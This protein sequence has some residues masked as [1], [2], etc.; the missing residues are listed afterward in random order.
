MALLRNLRFH[1]TGWQWLIFPSRSLSPDPL[2]AGSSY[3]SSKQRH[4]RQTQVQPIQTP[5]SPVGKEQGDRNKPP[6]NDTS[7]K[8]K[9]TEALYS[10]TPNDGSCKRQRIDHASSFSINKDITSVKS[11]RARR[12]LASSIS[13]PP[14]SHAASKRI[15]HVQTFQPDVFDD[16]GSIVG[17]S[18]NISSTAPR[19]TASDKSIRATPQGP[20]AMSVASTDSRSE[21]RKR[22]L[23]QLAD[24]T[25]GRLSTRDQIRRGLTDERMANVRNMLDLEPRPAE[26]K[27]EHERFPRKSADSVEFELNQNLRQN[28]LRQ[29]TRPE[30]PIS[31]AGGSANV[32]DQSADREQG[33]IVDRILDARIAPSESMI[34]TRIGHTKEASKNLDPAAAKRKH[35]SPT[36]HLKQGEIRNFSAGPYRTAGSLQVDGTARRGAMANTSLSS[37]ITAFGFGPSAPRL[38]RKSLK[39][40]SPRPESAL[41]S[42]EHVDNTNTVQVSGNSS[43]EMAA[44]QLV[45]EQAEHTRQLSGDSAVTPRL[46]EVRAAPIVRERIFETATAAKV[47]LSDNGSRLDLGDTTLEMSPFPRRRP[48]FDDHGLAGS[49]DPCSENSNVKASPEVNRQSP[50][51]RLQERKSPGTAQNASGSQEPRENE[52]PSSNQ[53]PVCYN[54][55]DDQQNEMN[56]IHEREKLVS[57]KRTNKHFDETHANCFDQ[58]PLRLGRRMA[59]TP[60]LALADVRTY[61]A[62]RE[63]TMIESCVNRDAISNPKTFLSMPEVREAL[64]KHLKD[65][66]DDHQYKVQ[67]ELAKALDYQNAHIQSLWTHLPSANFNGMMGV[68]HSSS[69]FQ[70]MQPIDSST[71]G[72]AV[73]KRHSRFY[74][75]NYRHGR[76]TAK[77][78]TACPISS[79]NPHAP[80]V[81]GFTGDMPKF[82]HYVSIDRNILGYNTRQMRVWPYF[83]MEDLGG[84]EETEGQAQLKLHFDLDV[85]DWPRKVHRIQQVQTY[86]PYVEAF[87][88]EIGCSMGDILY[89]LLEP[90]EAVIEAASKGCKSRQEICTED[91]NR[92]SSSTRW[93]R[94]F[95][96]LTKPSKTALRKAAIAC[97]IFSD[98]VARYS[99]YSKDLTM[100]HIA[101]KSTAACLVEADTGMEA[102]AA[103]CEI[104][105]IYDCPYHGAMR[106]HENSSDADDD[107][108]IASEDA[109]DA[110]YPPN[111]NYKV[112]VTLP[113]RSVETH[114]H[115]DP[116]QGHKQSKGRKGVDWWMEKSVSWDHSERGPFYPCYHPGLACDQAQCRCFRDK[117]HCEKACGCSA[118]C[119][120]QFH[121]CT[122]K[123]GNKKR[124]LQ[125]D[126]CECFKMNRE[127]DPD[128]CGTCGVQSVLNPESEDTDRD[129]IAET[130][131]RNAGIQLGRPKRAIL[132]ASKVHGYGLFAG[133]PI[134][135][136]EYVGE[137][138]GEIITKSETERRGAIYAVQKLSYLFALNRDQEIDSQRFGN[139]IRFINHADRSSRYRNVYP[140]IMLCNMAHRIGM[141]ALKDIQVGEELFFDYGKDYHQHLYEKEPDEPDEGVIPKTK[142]RAL[143]DTFN[144][145]DATKNSRAAIKSAKRKQPRP[146]LAQSASVSNSPANSDHERSKVA[147]NKLP[148]HTHLPAARKSESKDSRRIKRGGDSDNSPVPTRS[149]TN[150]AS[151]LFPAE[152]RRV[153][154]KNSP[155]KRMVRSR[156]ITVDDDGDETMI[157]Y[158]VH[159][160][161]GDESEY[162]DGHEVADS[163]EEEDED[164]DEDD[165]RHRRRP[166]RRVL[167]GRGDE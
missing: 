75:E 9:A 71:N 80:E 61:S 41:A 107:A 62:K 152:G 30:T 29:R 77:G 63:P 37:P 145:P 147:S 141:F 59:Y 34:Q 82:S 146:P 79:Y 81:P 157:Q 78:D 4:T 137:Y 109:L 40:Y 119:E 83:G 108:S 1:C 42:K 17:N 33:H 45:D 113:S 162:D 163:E 44:Q 64:E 36:H 114:D 53:A 52:G 28:V 138:V 54:D 68:A 100:W 124:C 89:Y 125:D 31:S 139:K 132:G 50:M 14:L 5:K 103:A 122:C 150:I 161:E 35:Q 117:V 102:F 87:L 118:A 15:Q 155:L 165:I 8:R 13:P 135:R 128:L 123:R 91:F 70:D 55:L 133:E 22:V 164:G 24:I 18:H 96:S 143:I 74:I 158:Q 47:G 144:N 134:G 16:Y 25:A 90:D 48:V 39:E 154:Q 12:S 69:P 86:S 65:L 101:R 148:A 2:H 110:D 67:A 120:R 142:N 130:C 58:P 136:N 131:C 73:A 26:N 112:R 156:R 49:G 149:W 27:D 11:G 56:A 23:E 84:D 72:K 88:E 111:I 99:K 60:P 116:V 76:L 51:V 127:C 140:K 57:T 105:H 43:D 106:E 7:L 159:D 21:S 66:H 85:E 38:A 121:G 94:V 46:N 10:S 93:V 98:A 160:S 97:S 3:S 19:H 115:I 167:R 166:R 151:R 126:R 129:L 153:A 6:P 32:L 92:S 95:S 104:C 20:R